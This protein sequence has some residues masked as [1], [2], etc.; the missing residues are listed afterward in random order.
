LKVPDDIS[1]VGFDD[2]EFA[3]SYDPP[4]TTI[5]QARRDMGRKAM[6]TLGRLIADPRKPK[7]DVLLDYKLS[8]RASSAPAWRIVIRLPCAVFENVAIQ[9]HATV[10]P[11]TITCGGARQWG[12]RPR[13][14]G[15]RLSLNVCFGPLTKTFRAS[16]SPG[17]RF[18]CGEA[19]D[20][21]GDANLETF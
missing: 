12:D 7:T 6:E 9:T 10:S 15:G 3:Q 14:P 20:P 4:L 1:I 17:A 5:Y 2:I 21:G 19:V 8:V 18:R 13:G 11:P 16:A